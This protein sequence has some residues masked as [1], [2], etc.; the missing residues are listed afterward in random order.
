MCI[1]YTY[2]GCNSYLNRLSQCCFCTLLSLRFAE[3]S[4]QHYGFTLVYFRLPQHNCKVW[5]GLQT[6]SS[7][8]LLKKN[9]TVYTLSP[10]WV[11]MSWIKHPPKKNLT[12]LLGCGRFRLERLWC[13]RIWMKNVKEMETN[14]QEQLDLFSTEEWKCIHTYSRVLYNSNNKKNPQFG[15]NLYG[16][17]AGIEFKFN[18]MITFGGLSLHKSTI[19]AHS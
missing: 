12:Q 1:H 4:P 7:A 10:Q 19:S 9:E 16:F 6:C 17:V 5:F 13:C 2:L 15:L 18:K 11:A 14:T 8:A 3:F